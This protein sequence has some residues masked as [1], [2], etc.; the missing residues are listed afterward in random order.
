MSA[1]ARDPVLIVGAGP[2]GLSLAHFLARRGVA[3]QVFEA[4]S[5][6]ARD[7]RA[8]TFHP[9][10]LDML[11]DDGVADALVAQG[12]IADRW[13]YLR[14]D[15]GD[16]AVFDV[17]V[18]AD[19]TAYPF[20]LQCEQFRLTALLGERL[21]RHPAAAL[22]FGSRLVGVTQ[23]EAGVVAAIELN[24]QVTNHRGS[25][26]VGADGA[27]SAVRRLLG[28]DLKGSTYEKTNITVVIDFPFEE[29]LSNMLFVNYV[30]TADSHYSLMRVQGAWR[31]GFSPAAGQ[32]AEAAA[33]EA[34]IQRHLQKILATGAPYRIVHAGAYTVHRRIVDSF[35]HGRVLL[36][37]DAAHLNS[38]SGG[39]GMNSGIHDAHVLADALASVW[40][41]GDDRALDAYAETRRHVALEDVQAQ[42]DVNYRRHRETDPVRR[43]EIWAELKAV[44]NNTV[45]MRAYLLRSS[46]IES[47][48]RTGWKAPRTAA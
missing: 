7:M 24:G 34:N 2:V 45:R 33:A 1:A 14:V 26:L 42:A 30:W 20:R 6:L 37:G 16:A 46:L 38:P 22:S 15:T 21:A 18:L 13:Q 32:S 12:H 9:P 28:Q 39:M 8:S 29:H 36:A 48:S 5:E 35:R 19:L 17:G 4:E 40:H 43:E 10:T 3:V 11:A 44:A 23:T 41:G 25:Y 27:K 31:T 47:L